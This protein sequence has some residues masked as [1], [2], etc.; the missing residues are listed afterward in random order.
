MQSQTQINPELLFTQLPNEESWK[1]I[2]DKSAWENENGPLV[3]DRDQSEGYYQNGMNAL[4]ANLLCINSPLSVDLIINLHDIAFHDQ[5]D[6]LRMGMVDGATFGLDAYSFSI[7][8]LKELIDKIRND[9]M[10]LSFIF[11]N[12]TDTP[13]LDPYYFKLDSNKSSAELANQIQNIILNTTN[14][15]YIGLLRETTIE[16]PMI[17]AERFIERYHEEINVANHDDEKKLYAI[18]RFIQDMHQYHPFADGNGRTFIFLLLNRLLIQNHLLPS[19]VDDPYKFTC[20]SI[21]EL[22][23]E[24]KKG[25][26]NVEKLC[27]VDLDKDK[28]L[29]AYLRHETSLRFDESIFLLMLDSKDFLDN[30]KNEILFDQIP[31]TSFSKIYEKN[32]I[33]NLFKK[34]NFTKEQLIN[35]IPYCAKYKNIHLFYKIVE[36]LDQS[37]IDLLMSN[38]D[39]V[40]YLAFLFNVNQLRLIFENEHFKI[41]QEFIL[42]LLKYDQSF[43]TGNMYVFRDLLVYMKKHDQLEYFLK[44]LN[45]EN[46]EDILSFDMHGINGIQLIELFDPNLLNYCNERLG[47]ENINNILSQEITCQLYEEVYTFNTRELYYSVESEDIENVKIF[48]QTDMVNLK[49]IHSF[50][51]SALH[52]AVEKVNA[53]LVQDLLDHPEVD[54]NVS[55]PNGKTSLYLAIEQGNIPIIQILLSHDNIDPNKVLPDDGSTALHLAVKLGNTAIIHE[56]INHPSLDP[57]KPLLDGRTA[58][59]LAIENQDLNSIAKLF[60]SKPILEL[61]SNIN[62]HSLTQDVDIIRFFENTFLKKCAS[63]S[64]FLFFKHANDDDFDAYKKEYKSTSV[65]R[66]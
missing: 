10:P 16:E 59:H 57:T 9:H 54:P 66:D 24:V 63:N 62:I 31:D 39:S 34:V 26:R 37:D 48:L 3:F 21:K 22:V 65:K 7:E 13:S 61:A 28:S 20:Y 64:E 23:N 4:M 52:L 56:L 29:I 8:G 25:Q 45:D 30:E 55:L 5:T 43:M 36:H 2:I 11:S 41:D 19:A 58:L 35:I 14:S 60:E 38:E 53:S 12:D 42:K 40:Q 18:V 44:M 49:I 33:E 1:L 17:A 15:T 51:K 27:R 47:I 32:A 6:P 46:L 50:G